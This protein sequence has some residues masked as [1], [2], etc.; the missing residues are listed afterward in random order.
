MSEQDEHD[1]LHSGLVAFEQLMETGAEIPR[2]MQSIPL[3]ELPNIGTRPVPAG[4]KAPEK[5]RER[6]HSKY[7]V[8][9][10]S[11]WLNSD[12]VVRIREYPPGAYQ[13]ATNAGGGVQMIDGQWVELC[14]E[15]FNRLKLLI[16]RGEVPRCSSCG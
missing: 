15:D 12:H 9:G 3:A 6:V 1:E 13:E 8:T 16:S 11:Q 5:A 10:D 7:F 4:I 14:K 2:E